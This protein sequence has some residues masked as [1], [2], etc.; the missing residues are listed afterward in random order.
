MRNRCAPKG[1]TLIELLVVISI[2][3]LLV[4]ILL[5]ALAKAREQAQ[6]VRCQAHLKGIT[7]AWCTYAQENEQELVFACWDASQNET[8]TG[9]Y[10]WVGNVR[11]L[12][13]GPPDWRVVASEEEQIDVIQ[14]GKLWKYCPDAENYR[15]PM[16][17][18]A[19]DG[20]QTHMLT[21]SISIA[22]RGNPHGGL[23]LTCPELQHRKLS[24]IRR[25]AERIVFVDE[26]RTTRDDYSVVYDGNDWWDKPP[27]IHN[28]GT[29]FSFAD[30]HVEHWQWED[31]TTID[32]GLNPNR[33]YSPSELANTLDDL[34]RL[35]R[36]IWG[37]LGPN[38]Y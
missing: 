33:A 13:S 16:G 10:S 38:I 31:E 9:K 29:N 26:S 32:I 6:L 19:G 37:Q 1:F 18:K 25:A 14:A 27:I 3:A 20:E 23:P 8:G 11:T 36:A 24:A 34:H 30:G 28:K 15:C 7:L 35:Q 5:P 12:L 2:I 17:Q 4:S 21:Y 22:M